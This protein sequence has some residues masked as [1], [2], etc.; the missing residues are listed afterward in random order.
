[1]QESHGKGV[2]I[3]PVEAV[4][5]L[6]PTRVLSAVERA[7]LLTVLHAE[8]FQDRFIR[9]PPKPLPLPSAVWI[10]KPIP[11]GEKTQEEGH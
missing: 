11:P 6:A 7:G 8:R 3:H 2:A 5:H 10:S 1:M 4:T 9:R